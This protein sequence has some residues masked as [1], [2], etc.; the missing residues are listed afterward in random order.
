MQY[1]SKKFNDSYFSPGLNTANPAIPTMYSGRIACDSLTHQCAIYDEDTATWTES[2]P[3][4]TILSSTTS[5]LV[6]PEYSN[7]TEVILTIQDFSEYSS[8]DMWR[9]ETTAGA[10]SGPDADGKILWDLIE[11]GVQGEIT[12]QAV[13]PHRPISELMKA[14]VVVND[15]IEVDIQTL[16]YNSMNMTQTDTVNQ[17]NMLNDWVGTS[18]GTIVEESINIIDNSQTSTTTIIYL[19]H[20]VNVGDVLSTDTE[21]FNVQSTH[22]DTEYWVTPE[23]ELTVAPT[24]VYTLSGVEIQGVELE[25]INVTN[26]DVITQTLG[27][28]VFQDTRELVVNITPG[29]WS[30]ID[31]IELIQIP[32]K[33]KD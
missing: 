28:S 14:T 33:I 31:N 26:T 5:I 21:I 19:S 11:Y 17:S 15:Y 27:D 4:V 20:T 1:L 8:S 3:G 7:N 23:T 9:I 22:D 29:A 18:G 32:L 16:L 24:S 13:G 2:H 30:N 6:S 25:V 10:A 12:V